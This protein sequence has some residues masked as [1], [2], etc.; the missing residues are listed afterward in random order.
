M[1]RLYISAIASLAVLIISAQNNNEKIKS[2]T[3]HYRSE[4]KVDSKKL[5]HHSQ[6]NVG[7]ALYGLLPGL[8]IMQGSSGTNIFDDSPRVN[9]RGISTLGN[10]SPLII[11]DGF[12]R[13]IETLSLKEIE[14]VSVLTNAVA[15]AI[16]GVRGA[17][18]VVQITTKRGTTGTNASVNYSYGMATPFRMPKFADA[19]TYASALNEALANDEMSARYTAQEIEYF[20]SGEHPELYPNVDWQ[21]ELYN[22]N[23][24]VHQVDAEFDGGKNDFRY[25]TAFTYSNQQSIFA[26]VD[27]GN[28]YNAKPDKLH[29]NIRTNLDYK[30]GST[31]NISIN[32]LGRIQSQTRPGSSLNG[33]IGSMYNTPAAAFPVRVNTGEWGGT[34]LYSFNP[35]A[36]LSDKGFSEVIRRTMLADIRIVQDLSFFTEGLYAEVAVAYDNMANYLDTR[37]KDYEYKMPTGTPG[38]VT[39]QTFG[40]NTQLG[41]NS[42]LNNQEMASTLTG[43]AGYKFTTGDHAFDTKIKYEQLSQV[44]SGRNNTTKRQSVMGIVS[45][46][47]KNK[48]VADGVLNY[49]GSAVMPKGDY[50]SLYPAI[51][52]GWVVSNE[53][54][55]NSTAINLLKVNA[56]VGLSGSDLIG[57]DLE[58]QFFLEGGDYFFQSNNQRF[59]AWREGALG[60]VD[61]KMEQALKADVGVETSIFNSLSLSAAYFYEKRS[62]ILV[63]G[64]SVVSGVLG[65]EIPRLS[66]GEVSNQGVELVMDWRKKVNDFNISVSGN[67]TY[68]KNKIINMNEGFLPESYL[69]RTGGSLYQYY[70]LETDGFFES[71]AQIN[72]PNTPK[73]LFGDVK[74]GDIKY[75]NQNKDNVINE[76]DVVRLGYSN[77]PEIYYGINLHADYKNFGIDAQFQGVANRTIYLNESSLFFPLQNNT[78]IST[79]YLE[80]NERWTPE[81]ASTANLPRLTTQE[82]NNNFRVNDI[83]LKNG[84]FFKLRNLDVYYT[85]PGKI[86]KLTEARIYLRG[87]NL[88]S[89]DYLTYADPEMIT[90]NY[91]VMR[92]YSI[93]LNIKF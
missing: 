10:A 66:T 86:F 47:F 90:A 21:N 16:Y 64:Y 14:S 28:V 84:A 48:Y 5:K 77:M 50:F 8:Y 9:L 36:E 37:T 52:A 49:S 35:L 24:S 79:W 13:D 27:V 23:G 40:K 69:Y 76:F 26:P 2:D 53:S 22:S 85:F 89:L 70:G 75:V 59:T 92:T 63:P 56:S 31:T 4:I 62:N 19:A 17:N 65:I 7:D 87:S 57:H 41:F 93:G 68:A 43:I 3:T 51:S 54:F 12:E 15:S 30:L 34:N 74:P 45:Y 73:Q 82:N 72:D 71:V 42:S 78:N 1:K 60:V 80:E 83:W 81:T 88:F 46:N 38:N 20:K 6:V 29:M 18:G 44:R 58:K 11:I 25:Y 67:F 91:P 33:I 61:L 39:Y 55:F 32:L